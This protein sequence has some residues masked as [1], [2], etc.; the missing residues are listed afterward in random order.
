MTGSKR[1]AGPGQAERRSARRRN[2]GSAGLDSRGLGGHN[3]GVSF[4]S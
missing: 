1:V 3:D 4:L 2:T